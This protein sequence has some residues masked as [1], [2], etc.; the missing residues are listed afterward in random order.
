MFGGCQKPLTWINDDIW[1]I[2]FCEWN[3]INLHYPL[4]IH[5]FLLCLGSAQ[6]VI[7]VMTDS[8]IDY[9]RLVDGTFF[10]GGNFLESTWRH[11]SR[12]RLCRAAVFLLELKYLQIQKHIGKYRKM[13]GGSYVKLGQECSPQIDNFDQALEMSS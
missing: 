2:R 11:R 5:S 4:T 13:M 1:S 6:C 3:H 10:F 7:T 12:Y 9:P 8:F